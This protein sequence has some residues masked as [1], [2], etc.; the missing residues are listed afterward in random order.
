MSSKSRPVKHVV[1]A[2]IFN[3][4]GEILLGR[5]ARRKLWHFPGGCVPYGKKPLRQVKIEV[6][7]EMGLTCTK[8]KLICK[9]RSSTLA[10]EEITSYYL[11]E[12]KNLNA[13]ALC[14]KKEIDAQRWCNLAKEAPINLTDTMRVILWHPSLT[15]L[16][17][18]TPWLSPP[19]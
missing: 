17:I 3:E 8:A 9:I 10:G 16:L 5:Q 2:V 6:A 13:L 1:R 18:R 7:Q 4:H 14:D 11:V 19:L 15:K 12:V